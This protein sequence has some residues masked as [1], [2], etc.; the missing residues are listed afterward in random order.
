MAIVMQG[1]R[2]PLCEQPLDE[3]E[4]LIGFSA[5]L[6]VSHRLAVFSDAAFHRS[7]FE[8]DSRHLE[9]TELFRRFTAIWES[10]PAGLQTLDEIEAWGREAFKDFP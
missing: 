2:C 1:M 5:F 4:P 9:V 7:C 10:R 8:A 3:G 6:P